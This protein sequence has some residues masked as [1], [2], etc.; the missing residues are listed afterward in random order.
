MIFDNTILKLSPQAKFQ[1]LGDSQETV[2]VSMESGFLYT[3][4]ATTRSF[5]EAMDGRKAFGRI[6]EELL[7]QYHVSREKLQGDL[8]AMAEKLIQER[9]ILAVPAA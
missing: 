4:N 7:E 8:A 2:I 3:C 6:V 9:L 1:S 5:L